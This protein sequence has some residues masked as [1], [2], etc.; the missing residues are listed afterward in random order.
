MFSLFLSSTFADFRQRHNDMPKIST[1]HGGHLNTGQ[2][3]QGKTYTNI[4]T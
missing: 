3:D 4:F 1:R 2:N